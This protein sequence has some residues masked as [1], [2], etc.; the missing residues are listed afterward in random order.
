MPSFLIRTVL[1]KDPQQWW[2]AK[3][4]V[5]RELRDL[6]GIRFEEAKDAVEFCCHLPFPLGDRKESELVA[7]REAGGVIARAQTP[8]CRKP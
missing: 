2:C 1:P 4:R 3:V 6:T 8:P 7:L 5:M